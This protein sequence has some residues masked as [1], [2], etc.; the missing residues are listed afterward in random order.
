M[1]DDDGITSCEDKYLYAEGSIAVTPENLDGRDT[2]DDDGS[3]W[4]RGSWR[5][6][7][8]P[9]FPNA[10]GVDFDAF[11]FEDGG[12]QEDEEELE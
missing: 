5:R 8:R 1:T 9:K 6:D 7:T 10:I 2:I 4:D 12:E 3:G 11:G